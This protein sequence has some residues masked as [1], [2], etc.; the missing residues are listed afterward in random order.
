MTTMHNSITKEP[1]RPNGP[2]AGSPK[3]TDAGVASTSL[4]PDLTALADEAL[5]VLVEQG[6]ATMKWRWGQEQILPFRLTRARDE[7]V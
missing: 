2:P 5:A 3:P 7:G 1:P 4:L 6:Q